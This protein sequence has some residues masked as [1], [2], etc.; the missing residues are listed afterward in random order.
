MVAVTSDSARCPAGSDTAKSAG[1][2]R[3]LIA[4]DK[5]LDDTNDKQ[6]SC[7]ANTEPPSSSR[8]EGK[9]T[10]NDYLSSDMGSKS[11]YEG[12]KIKARGCPKA[13]TIKEP[14]KLRLD[15]DVL[16][17]LRASGDGWQTRINETLR[18]SLRLAGRD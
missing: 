5:T 18:A 3:C 15:A 14:V 7:C 8:I 13:V 10:T 11:L 16:A 2:Q 9:R 6:T 4:T 1:L 12:T 17:A